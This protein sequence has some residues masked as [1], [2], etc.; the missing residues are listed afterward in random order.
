MKMEGREER[1]GMLCVCVDGFHLV[2]KDNYNCQLFFLSFASVST[3]QGE[4]DMRHPKQ[5]PNKLSS[6]CATSEITE[7]SPL[8]EGGQQLTTDCLQAYAAYAQFA[9]TI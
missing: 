4:C 7:S 3:F 5:I 1:I 8:T 2:A 6:G 9:A